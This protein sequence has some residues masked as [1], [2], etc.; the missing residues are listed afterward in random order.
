MKK[1][2][3]ILFGFMI[4][5]LS[6]SQ[7]YFV[8]SGKNSAS[9]NFKTQYSEKQLN[10]DIG[11]SFAVGRSFSLDRHEIYDFETAL[12]YDRYK[13]YVGAPLSQV[14]YSLNYA[15]VD[16][17][18][19]F[20]IINSTKFVFRIRAGMSLKKMIR[21]IETIDEKIYPL[22]NFPEFKGLLIM[23]NIGLQSKFKVSKAIDLSLE[24]SRGSSFLN[25][26]QIKNQTL[27]ISNDQVMVGINFLK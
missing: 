18:F 25:T 20:S 16:N 27:S 10:S 15:G 26:G 9:L 1:T 8:R 17:A 24:Y 3:F 22:N 6:Y 12:I 7:Y 11:D 23:G 4:S 21:G 2:V 19:L 5:T 13:L 14:S